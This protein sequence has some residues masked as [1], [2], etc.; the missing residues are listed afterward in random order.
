MHSGSARGTG[1]EGGHRQR[2][3]QAHSTEAGRLRSYQEASGEESKFLV[4]INAGNSWHSA[5]C[6]SCKILVCFVQGRIVS[7]KMAISNRREL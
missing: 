1:G 3:Q 5:S 6:P 4:A 2:K 7:L